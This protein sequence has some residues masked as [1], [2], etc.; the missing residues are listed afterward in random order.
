MGK[1]SLKKKLIS[2][3]YYIFKWKKR[4]LIFKEKKLF[5]KKNNKFCNLKKVEKKR[6]L[7]SFSLEKKILFKLNRLLYQ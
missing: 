1:M 3:L 6:V 5:T 4:S 7:Y 2:L